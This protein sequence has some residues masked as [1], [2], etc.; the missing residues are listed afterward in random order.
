MADT[1]TYERRDAVALVSMDDGKANALSF[2]LLAALNEALDRAE[3]EEAGAVVITGRAGMLSGGFDLNVMRSGDMGAVADLVTTGGELFLRLYRSPTP[4]VA[5]CTG[6]AIAAGAFILLGAHRR[7]GDQ[8]PFKIQ[9]VE[10]AIGMVLP[11][12][13]VELC[14]CRLSKRHIEP[15]CIESFTYDPDGA[16]DAGFLDAVV[17]AGTAVD[18][19]VEEATRL[20]ALPA[21]AY[22]GNAAKV[23]GPGA[24][25]VAAAVTADRAG[26]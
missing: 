10:T 9:L 12:W 4:I 19:A 18:A 21:Q 17:P 25:R 5:A 14:R 13:A 6:H 16:A 23:R 11:D 8:G 3:A 15:A 2:D 22:A 26:R 1:V 7:V 24:D 20:A